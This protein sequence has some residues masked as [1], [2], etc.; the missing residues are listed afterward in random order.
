M[1]NASIAAEIA[2]IPASRAGPKWRRVWRKL[3]NLVRPEML[4]SWS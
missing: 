4:P 3:F 1:K 2:S